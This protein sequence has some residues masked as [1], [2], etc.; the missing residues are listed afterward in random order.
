MVAT[1]LRVRGAL[2]FIMLVEEMANDN[3]ASPTIP[4]IPSSHHP[5]V[6]VVSALLHMPI[7]KYSY[8]SEFQYLALMP[9][10]RCVPIGKDD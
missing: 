2:G 10:M 8:K 3:Y 1:Q 6:L 9:L 7:R 5:A 4:V